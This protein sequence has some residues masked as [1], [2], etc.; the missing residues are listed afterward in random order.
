MNFHF[1]WSYHSSQVAQTLGCILTILKLGQAHPD[2]SVTL[3][4][5]GNRIQVLPS[6]YMERANRAW[7]LLDHGRTGDPV[8]ADIDTLLAHADWHNQ[9][10]RLSAYHHFLLGHMQQAKTQLQ[11]NMRDSATDGPE[12]SRLLAQISLAQGDTTAAIAAYQHGWNSHHEE[13]D[14]LE[15]LRCMR[16]SGRA[17]EGLLQAGL[18]RYPHS[19][20]ATEAIFDTYLAKKDKSNTKRALAIAEQAESWW[21]RS[22]DWA[23]R[24]AQ[25]L[26]ALHKRKEARRILIIALDLLD[27]E[28]RIAINAKGTLETR[29]EIFSL[30]EIC[31]R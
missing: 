4:K 17:Q 30:I 31:S 10:M 19:P 28:E 29:Q 26:T 11:E 7:L 23:F 6:A 21:P 8:H 1:P 15:L 27:N 5:I 18:F 24:R 3:E 16:V 14:Y 20:G 25:A 9:G 12:Q 2:L 13:S 22:V